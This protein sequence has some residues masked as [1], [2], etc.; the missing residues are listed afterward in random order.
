MI[1]E[2]GAYFHQ[3]IKTM[4]KRYQGRWNTNMMVNYCWCWKREVVGSSYTSVEQIGDFCN[5]KPV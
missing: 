3:D 4:E 1:E 5:P 2:Q